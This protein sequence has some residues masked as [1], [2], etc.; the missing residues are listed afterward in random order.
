LDARG[1]IFTASYKNEE[2]EERKNEEH[3]S[4]EEDKKT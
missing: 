4:K 3:G 2:H 1:V